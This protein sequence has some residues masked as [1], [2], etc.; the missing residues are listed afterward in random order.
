[1][2][3]E[4]IGQ[5]V[6]YV[7]GYG[8]A[9]TIESA[10]RTCTQTDVGSDSVGFVRRLIGRGHMSPTEF[11][12]ADAMIECDRGIQQEL[13][14]HREFSYNVEST[15][16]CDY[17]KKPLR[18]V[19]KPPEGMDVPDEWVRVLE[20]L[21]R[22][23]AST[24][25]LM[26]RSGVPRDYARKALPLATASKMRMGGNFRM[27]MEMLP[28]RLDRAAHAEVREIASR[29]LCML[30]SRFAGVFDHIEEK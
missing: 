8:G 2:E 13:T 1:M 27:W 21:C 5:S 25:E 22:D 28:K 6:E 24:Y 20:E 10:A 11:G 4:F 26:V 16:W 18:F 17:T 23:C 7:G 3:C 9:D 14:R 30:K 12:Y 19:T 15:R 29:M